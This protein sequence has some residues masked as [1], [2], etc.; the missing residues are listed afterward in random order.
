MELSVG[1]TL[2]ILIA[3]GLCLWALGFVVYIVCKVISNP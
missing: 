2:V 3:A 1:A